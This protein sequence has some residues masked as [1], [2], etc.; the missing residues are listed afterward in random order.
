MIFSPAVHAHHHRTLAC[1][2]NIITSHVRTTLASMA[3]NPN[4]SGG[5]EIAMILAVHTYVLV[6]SSQSIKSL[7]NGQTSPKG[8]KVLDD[9]M[10]LPALTEEFEVELKKYLK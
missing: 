7:L 9:K 2:W 8:I 3:S 10:P 4:S 5:P 1:T 6:S